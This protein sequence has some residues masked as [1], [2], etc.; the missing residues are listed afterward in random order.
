MSS[1]D[2]KKMLYYKIVVQQTIVPYKEGTGD[3]MAMQ[4]ERYSPHILQVRKVNLY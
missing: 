1:K 3:N 4:W 2:S